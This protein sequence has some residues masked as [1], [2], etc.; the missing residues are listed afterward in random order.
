MSLDPRI[1]KRAVTQGYVIGPVYHGTSQTFS[2]F[3][4]EKANVES[5]FGAGFYFTASELDAEH[6]YGRD[7]APDITAKIDR[8]ADRL[9]D[10]NDDVVNYEAYEEARKQLIGDG[11]FRILTVALRMRNPFWIARSGSGIPILGGRNPYRRTF[12]D[13]Q[14]TWNEDGDEPKRSEDYERLYQV[15]FDLDG[16]H[17]LDAYKM[18]SEIAPHLDEEGTMTAEEFVDLFLEKSNVIRETEDD[19][20]NLVFSEIFR[21]IIEGMGFDGIID[22]LAGDRFCKRRMEMNCDEVHFIVFDSSQIKLLD[23]DTGVPIEKRFDPASRIISNP[24]I[25]PFSGIAEKGDEIL[26]F[27]KA[28]KDD[29]YRLFDGIHTSRRP[30]HGEVQEIAGMLRK[31]GVFAVTSGSDAHLAKYFDS[32]TRRGKTVYASRPKEPERARINAERKRNRA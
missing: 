17:G 15:V 9:R 25:N 14:A 8:L 27:D 6:N 32:V 4:H 11:G 29:F 5:F 18:W 22:G 23:E 10:E 3:L 19:H 2:E 7:S 16:M 30:T 1:V 12:F 13:F 28:T 24:S 26:D 20:G 21:L 31:D